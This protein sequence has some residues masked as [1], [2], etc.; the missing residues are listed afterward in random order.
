MVTEARNSYKEF[1]FQIHIPD[2]LVTYLKHKMHLNAGIKLLH[3]KPHVHRL[4]SNS[5]TLHVKN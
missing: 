2:Q 4:E 3:G 5:C 1:L